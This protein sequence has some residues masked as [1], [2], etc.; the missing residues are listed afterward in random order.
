MATIRMGTII[1]M[2]DNLRYRRLQRVA[3]SLSINSGTY[4]S[5]RRLEPKTNKHL[6]FLF[7]SATANHEDYIQ[8]ED[9]NNQGQQQQLY[10]V[11]QRVVASLTTSTTTTTTATN[12]T[13][14]NNL[15]PEND[16]DS[17]TNAINPEANVK[18]VSTSESS[19]KQ[20]NGK[21][22]I[23]EKFA[24]IQSRFQEI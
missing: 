18:E 21:R 3:A 24:G 9:V 13:N 17:S 1:R 22:L 12:A 4:H 11:S 19:D 20:T 16:W 7:I 5:L 23:Y 2:V 15:C 10:S 6:L 8:T 14:F